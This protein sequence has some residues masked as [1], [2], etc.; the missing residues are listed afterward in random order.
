[1]IDPS[2]APTRPSTFTSCHH[3]RSQ[4][5]LIVGFYPEWGV[6][7]PGWKKPSLHKLGVTRRMMAVSFCEH[8][9]GGTEVAFVGSWKL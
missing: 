8:C 2:A 5:E 6:G 9:R 7:W 1:M 3:P 4:Q